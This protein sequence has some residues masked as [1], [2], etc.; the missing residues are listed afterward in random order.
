MR[1][2]WL[3][4]GY[5]AVV[6]VAALATGA[7]TGVLW[8]IEAGVASLGIGVILLAANWLPRRARV[9]QVERGPHPNGGMEARLQRVRDLQRAV[10]RSEARIEDIRGQQNQL[11]T[12]RRVRAASANGRE[13]EG[14]KEQAAE[15][16]TERAELEASVVR[17][18]ADVAALLAEL[19]PDAVYL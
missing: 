6:G 9:V 3:A 11:D 19:G 4:A 17:T 12:K 5:T 18:H 10:G 14:L 8:V 7:A 16:R 1:D 15:L 2:L 13:L